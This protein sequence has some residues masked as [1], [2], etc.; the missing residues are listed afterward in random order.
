MKFTDELGRRYMGRWERA[1]LCYAADEAVR[2][3][4][5]SGGAVS[6]LLLH[7]LETGQIDGA[8]VTRIACEDGRIGSR[9]TLATDRDGVLAARTSKYFPVPLIAGCRRL[10]AEFS[11]RV[12]IVALP[13]QTAALR[14]M[15]ARDPHLAERLA[16]IITL[17]CNHTS[18]R[19][20]LDKVLARKGIDQERVTEFAFKRGWWRG[21]MGGTLADGTEFSFP[22]TYYSYYQNLN[23]FILPRCLRCHDHTGYEGDFSAGDAWLPEMKRE[24]IKHTVLLART[25]EATAVLG[26]LADSGQL[27]GQPVSARDVFRSQKRAITYHYNVSA[28]ARAGRWHGIRIE[29]TVQARVRWNDWLVAHMTLLNYRW[30]RSQRYRDWIFAVPRPIIMAYC[31]L[32]KL[33]ENF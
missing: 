10:L 25:P 17:F 29:D 24:P 11:G 19:H 7:L 27:I 4:A 22:Y 33:L 15:A 3:G 21:R 12:A 8:I 31:V 26:E 23:F 1:L 28:R 9:V 6:A 13:C 5:A 14:R 2:T 16:F 30:S 20:L 18:E 32:M